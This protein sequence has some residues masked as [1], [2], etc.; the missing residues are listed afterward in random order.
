MRGIDWAPPVSTAA[1]A[2]L[3]LAIYRGVAGSEQIQAELFLG[4]AASIPIAISQNTS[5]PIHRHAVATLGTLQSTIDREGLQN[6]SVIVVG[7]VLQGLAAVASGSLSQQKK[8]LRNLPLENSVAG[9]VRPAIIHFSR[10][11]RRMFGHPSSHPLAP[12]PE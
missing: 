9:N 10:P 12:H 1:Q 11:Q 7:D 5:L 3:T 6:P 2:K 8:S 4:R